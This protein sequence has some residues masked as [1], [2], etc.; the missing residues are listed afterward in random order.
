MSGHSSP[1]RHGIK[2]SQV[3]GKIVVLK[4]KVVADNVMQR[5]VPG[6]IFRTFNQDSG[7]RSGER[8]CC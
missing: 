6:E 2:E 3:G 8:L 1:M 4:N 5:G 7:K